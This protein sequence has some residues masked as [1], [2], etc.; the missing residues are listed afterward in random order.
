[1]QTVLNTKP[2]CLF[3]KALGF[4]IWRKG[5]GGKMKKIYIVIFAMIL[6]S[7]MVRSAEAELLFN[8]GAEQGDTSGWT[9]P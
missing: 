5:G 7:G 1:M 9:N 8:G 3:V 2:S 6:I 4:F